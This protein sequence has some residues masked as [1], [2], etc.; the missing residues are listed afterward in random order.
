MNS[1]QA[2]K[3][4]T[5]K[6][7]EELDV[8]VV[9][10]GFAGLYQ[11]D[12]LR[13]LGFS[14]RVF[15][16]GADIGGIWYWNCYPGARVDTHGPIY[17]YSRED[18]WREWDYSELFPTWDEVREYFYYVDKKLDLSR[19]V[20]FNTRVSAAE[21]DEDC[22]QWIIQAEDGT[23]VRARFFVLCTGFASKPYV[24]AIEGL[25]DFGGEWHHTA[26]WPQEGLDFT[27]KRVGVIGTGASGVQVIQE[28][29]QQVAHL[30]VFQRTPDLALPMRNEK[31]DEETQRRM[32]ED[33]P[34]RFRKR[35]E[36]F[37]GFDF[38]FI[39]KSAFEV[40]PDDRQ[41]IYEDLWAKGGF[42]PW[43][44]TF[45]DVL[46]DEEANDTAYAFWRDKT[47]ARIADPA[48][49]EKLAPMEPL[50]PF[51]VRR[52]SLEQF[53]FEV[54][55]KDNVRLVDV[56]ET[57]IER[58]TSKGVK[59]SD[60]EHELDILVMATG[61]DAVTGGLTSIDIH[62]T[63]GVT[64]K[65]K[66]ANGVRAYLGVASTSFPN[67]LFIYGPQSP[68]GF[69]N[70]PTCAELQGDWVVECLEYM[71]QS[72]LARIEATS[73]AEEAWRE[74]VSELANATLF[75]RADS[76]YMAAN[77]PGKPRE[78]LNYPGGLPTYLQKCKESAEKGYEGFVLG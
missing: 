2:D 64:L 54:F 55:N 42:Y 20:R 68:S 69:C 60:G 15:E 48:V 4:D 61:F 28:A 59:T 24:P 73:A 13:K 56:R 6:A 67:L 66:W 35:G 17:Q 46:L 22:D 72:G 57:P 21:F 74:H 16:A 49:A 18:L 71:R 25:E 7:V 75:P 10:A 31:L 36:A 12:R 27:G 52:P 29:S 44:G 37:G 40:S 47:R 33:Y 9:G 77:I 43:L 30:T 78:I 53:Y 51:G 1:T 39:E 38:D 19:D 65:E 3:V 63:Q 62:G 45:Q 34:A 41:A 11:L 8:L 5:S 14:V 50:D 32:K 70:G 23:V 26:R 76:W 58:I